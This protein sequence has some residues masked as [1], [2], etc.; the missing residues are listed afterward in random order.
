MRR[1]QQKYSSFKKLKIS[2]MVLWT[3]R[4]QFLQP[5]RTLFDIKPSFS[6]S[7]S[8]HDLKN[9]NFSHSYRIFLHTR[10]KQFW[11]HHRNSL[12]NCPKVFSSK[13]GN[14]KKILIF[15]K[16]LISFEV[17]VLTCRMMFWKH[18]RKA[19]KGLQIFSSKSDWDEKTI[20]LSKIFFQIQC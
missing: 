8:D 3:R 20:N 7:T 11:Q 13:S 15:P 16:R 6:P 1:R 12:K 17:F 9:T 4:M 2:N 19:H 5:C 14:D 18:P 10:R